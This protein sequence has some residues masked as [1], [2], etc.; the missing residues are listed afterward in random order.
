VLSPG[1]AFFPSCGTPVD[2]GPQETTQAPISGI[3]AI[4]KETRAQ[5]YW[6]KRFIAYVI[7]WVIVDLALVILVTIAT[8]PFLVLSG[9]G[10]FSAVGWGD[11]SIL[12]GVVLVLYFVAFEVLA[13]ASIGKRV[14]GLKVVASGGRVPHFVEALV[15]NI[16]KLFWLLLI[17]DTIVGLAVSKG[18]TQ[19]YADKL[20]GTSVVDA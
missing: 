3:D 17:L 6:V 12:A 20:M 11:F 14:M 4:M 18:Y 16:S 8:L 19:K 7:D 5:N 10:I 2:T 9:P 1:A 15:R 13:G